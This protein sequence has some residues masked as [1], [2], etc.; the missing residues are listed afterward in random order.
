MV[1]LLLVEPRIHIVSNA[2]HILISVLVRIPQDTE[3]GQNFM[4]TPCVESNPGTARMKAKWRWSKEG[5]KANARL[6]TLSW[7]L[8]IRKHSWYLWRHEPLGLG[9]GHWRGGGG[10]NHVSTKTLVKF[11]Y[12]LLFTEGCQRGTHSSVFR[13]CAAPVPQTAAK[14]TVCPIAS[15]EASS[16]PGS[17]GRSGSFSSWW[18]ACRCTP[19]SMGSNGCRWAWGQVYVLAAG[20]ACLLW[21]RAASLA[22]ASQAALMYAAQNLGGSCVGSSTL[23]FSVILLFL[24]LWPRCYLW[25]CILSWILSWFLEDRFWSWQ[26]LKHF[27]FLQ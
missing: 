19:S 11:V 2:N 14:E 24:Y 13:G 4:A 17:G 6:C 18:V 5:G 12:L 25:L 9:A 7:S 21:L 23:I 3:N 22:E 1:I 10:A 8:R 15:C 20:P 16:E 26:L 27:Q